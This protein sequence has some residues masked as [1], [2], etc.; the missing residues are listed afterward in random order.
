MITSLPT[1]KSKLK[2]HR[3]LLEYLRYSKDWWFYYRKRIFFNHN[4]NICWQS[5]VN[6][7]YSSMSSSCVHY[8]RLFARYFGGTAAVA[9]PPFRPSDPAVCGSCP[10]VTPIP[11]S[12]RLGDL[13]CL[14]CVY[15][16]VCILL[17]VQCP[18][19]YL[20]VFIVFFVLCSISFSTL[21]LLVG[22]PI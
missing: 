14:L 13:L 12:C 18:Y 21:I 17:S 6:Y 20:V 15:P 2:C 4:D 8:Y 19:V 1:F 5:L 7:L 9:P 10:L 3:L 16:L 22:S 11:Y